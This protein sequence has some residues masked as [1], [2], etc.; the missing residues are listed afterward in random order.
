MELFSA[1]STEPGTPAARAKRAIA[2]A[3]QFEAL[4]ASSML[5]SM[6]RTV[7]DNPLVPRSMGEEI[8]TGMLDDQYASLLAS[9]NSFGLAQMLLRDL[10]RQD[11]SLAGHLEQSDPLPTAAVT[12]RA[13]HPS[14]VTGPPSA[15]ARRLYGAVGR[16][17]D[18]IT[19]VSRAYRLDPDLVAA[20]MARESAGNPAA[21]S[22]AGAKGLMQ[23]MDGTAREVG[24]RDSFNP[25]ENVF[26]GAR[27][28]RRMLDRFDQD[29]RKALASYNAGPSAVERHNGIPPFRETQEYVRAVIRLRNE[30]GQLRALERGRER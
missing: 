12:M 29:L 4:F 30:F 2:V 9:R 22:R 24:T 1:P 16:W 13:P 23:L 21:V 5:R 19:E 11:P 8:Y 6:R 7:A 26:G 17:N 20:V 25:R 27:Y 10:Q 15:S 14:P 3:T 18:L 28:L